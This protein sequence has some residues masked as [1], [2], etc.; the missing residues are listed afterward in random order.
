MLY[1]IETD[2]SGVKLKER[3]KDIEVAKIVIN[4]IDIASEECPEING[5]DDSNI[6]LKDISMCKRD[7]CS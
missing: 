5:K 4:E 6:D 1:I 2:E 3:I 7:V